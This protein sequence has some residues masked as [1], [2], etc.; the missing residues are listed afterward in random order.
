M[1]LS[2]KKEKGSGFEP[3]E[4]KGQRLV[5][6]VEKCSLRADTSDYVNCF[7]FLIILY[8]FKIVNYR[9]PYINA[10]FCRGT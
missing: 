6:I 7:S 4:I 9:Q 3:V 1:G 2:E 8:L 10:L 5:K